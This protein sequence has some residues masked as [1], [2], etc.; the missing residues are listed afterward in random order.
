MARVFGFV[1]R[2][3]WS[4]STFTLLTLVAAPI[5][6]NQIT[7]DL[8]PPDKAAIVVALLAVVAVAVLIDVRRQQ[9]VAAPADTTV[10]HTDA[11]A[12]QLA[13]ELA[14]LRALVDAGRKLA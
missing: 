4:S 2:F 13:V 10:P 1:R 5:L 3:P 7:E 8:P 12:E 11:E 14:R 9:V 6:A